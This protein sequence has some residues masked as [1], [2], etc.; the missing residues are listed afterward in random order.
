MSFCDKKVVNIG[1]NRLIIHHQCR[2][3][4]VSFCTEYGIKTAP[5]WT[6]QQS[7]WQPTKD[8]ELA[9]ITITLLY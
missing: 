4:W 6:Q 8:K 9:G 3:V 2:P 7:S 5:G 1:Q